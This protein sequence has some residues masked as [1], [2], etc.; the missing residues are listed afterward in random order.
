MEPCVLAID[1]GASSGR[2]IAALSDGKTLRCHEIHRF[3]NEPVACCGSL[4]WDVLFLFNQIKKGIALAAQRYEVKSLAIDTWGVD[5]GLLD[6]SGRLI[7]NPVCYRDERTRGIL[8]VLSE[9]ISMPELFAQTGNTPDEINTLMQLAALKNQRPEVL[10]RAHRL[11][12]M[13]D[14]IGYFLTGKQACEFTIA[15]TSQCLNPERTGIHTK[16]LE[17][18]GLRPD[19]FAT[20]RYPGE[21]L[22]T[23][24][25][26]IA[27]EC[28]C[29]EIDVLLCGAHDTA[30]AIYA[31]P[32]E[33]DHPLF[34]SCGTWAI[35]GQILD[36]PVITEASARLGVSNEGS[37]G[38]KTRLVRNLT[39]LWIIQQCKAELE[40]QGTILTYDEIEAMM[41][42]AQSY[43]GLIDTQAPTF[44]EF[45][46]TIERIHSYLKATG[47]PLPQTH[48][49]LFWCVYQSLA[50]Q[51][52]LA[53]DELEA[54]TGQPSD[55]LYMVGGGCQSATLRQKIADATGKRVI[56]GPVEATA[57]GNIAVQLI[58]EGLAAD[59]AQITAL[60]QNSEKIMTAVP[61]TSMTSQIVRLK[62][63][64]TQ[65]LDYE[66]A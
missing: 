47:Q 36:Q 31:L 5:F 37:P 66:V 46:Q 16:L 2:V 55:T 63:L 43:G 22:G 57:L 39:G 58:A 56:A 62:Q 25:P 28:G 33:E 34:L 35:T 41:D 42:P 27:A 64:K 21:V 13:P 61:Q 54:L 12:F 18:L 11:L 45:G 15:S 38:G 7:E 48:G 49:E 23:L 14:L 1:L 32:T 10:E 3:A 6:K 52:K 19:L 51:M 4:Y 44:R 8:D 40:R 60:I 59:H 24:K 53:F 9:T 20:L 26:E 17:R 30:S 50:A 65:A 29:G